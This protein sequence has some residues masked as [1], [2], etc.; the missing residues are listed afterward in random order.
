[1]SNVI[2]GGIPPKVLPPGVA[3]AGREVVNRGSSQRSTGAQTDQ[4]AALS[5][6][7]GEAETLVSMVN[8]LKTMSPPVRSNLLAGLKKSIATG[9][10]SPNPEKVAGAVTKALANG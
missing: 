5:Q 10:Y 7:S 4:P 8:Q 1:M 3:E 6:F 2:N 9:S